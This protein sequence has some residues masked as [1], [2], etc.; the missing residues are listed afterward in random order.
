[1]SFK[2]VA[3]HGDFGLGSV[4]NMDGELIAYHGKFY[5]ISPTGKMNL[6]PPTQ[7]TPYAVVTFFKPTQ[8]FKI[9]NIS[10]YKDLIDVLNKHISNRN[11]P[12]AISVKGDYQYLELRAVRGAKPPYPP[13][14][15]LA[16]HQAILK[17]HNVKGVGIGFFFPPYLAHVN[18]P[19]YHIHFI[20]ADR[21]TGGHILIAKIKQATVSLMPMY[22]WTMQLPKTKA[23]QQ[24][25]K[26]NTDYSEQ[27][28]RSFGVG[29]QNR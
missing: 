17:L 6:I 19:G 4:A 24:S 2:T 13:F 27:L 21:K 18:T 10:S 3:Q 9:K 7:T 8:H 16:K 20:T 11:I 14:S 1:M 15:E 26:L 29:I 28:K 5:R 22:T 12:Y 23:Y 25:Q